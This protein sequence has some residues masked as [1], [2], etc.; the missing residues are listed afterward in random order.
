M[1][2]LDF[3]LSLIDNITKP[4]RQVQ[5]AVSNFA[6]DSQVAFGKIA[7]G[8][9]A[10]AGAFWSIKNILD[11]AIEMND[12]MMT[13]SLQ[14]IDDGIMSK[15]SKDALMFAARYGK[16]SIDFVNSTTAISKAINN[17]TQQDLPQL[18]R[19]TNTTAAALKATSTE[20]SEYMGQMFNQFESQANAVG[21][22]KFA[23]DLAGKAV[24]MSKA[25]GISM[26]EITGLMEG[27]K[28]AGTQFGVGIDEQLAVLGELQRTLGGESSGAY[29]AFL[30][31]AS[32]SG[33][34]LGLSFVNAS[35]QMLSMPEMLDKLQAKYGTSIEGNL[36]AQK[37]IEA[38]FGDSAV[39]VK[40]L[41]GNVDILRKNIGFLGASDGMKR[42]TEQAAKLANPWERLMSIW[43]SI[44]IAIGM[45]LLP[46]INPLIDK[47]AEGGQTLVRWF[48][49]FPNIARWVGYITMGTLGFAAAGA[50]ANIVMG[51]SKFIMAGLSI[52]MG[53]FSGV[54]KIGTAA[55]WL[56][57]TAILA[58]NTALKF[59]RSTLLAVRIAAM[60]AGVSFS[61]MSW[62]ILLIIGAIALLAYGIYKLIQ[63]WD[64]VKAAV[65]NTTAFKVV[66]I[67]VRAV[68]LVAMQAWEWM[69]QKWQEFT[70]YFADTWAFKALMIVIDTLKSA[71]IQTWQ[72]ITDGWNA[73]C[74]F[75][76]DSPIDKTFEAMGNSIKAIFSRVWQSITDSFRSVYNTIVETL[77]YLPGVNIETKTT[78]TV[79]GSP[80]PAGAAGLLVGGQLSGVEKGGISRQISNNRTQSVDNSKRFDNVN[81]TVTNGMSPTDLAEWT[82]LDNG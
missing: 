36:K 14:G 40:Q 39:V 1:S 17:V 55:I 9:A 54:L 35:G 24:Y 16:S 28:N 57:R 46:V 25:F 29:E 49:L 27:A 47:L 3:T 18:T 15:V 75:F 34:K 8:G 71:F 79:D 21:H 44:R 12:A 4:I 60:A 6:R 80:A 70:A 68:G 2:E 41:Y 48:T 23:E 77:N 33:K 63:H 61:F 56:Y 67:A 74:N 38:A 78:G 43:Q 73:V 13:A 58:W 42:T 31:T 37:E 20:A 7:V 65:M 26:A 62:P 69:S 50:A 10:L 82:A 30:K 11:P 22:V 19:I 32:D 76:S 66:A 5:S 52:I 72:A 51:I 81:I 53:G 64:D 45:T 59:I